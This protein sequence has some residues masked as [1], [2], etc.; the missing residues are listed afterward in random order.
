VTAHA[1]S[2]PLRTFR[3]VL[4]LAVLAPAAAGR[5]ADDATQCLALA[6]YWESKGCSR[7]DMTA[8]GWV[9]LNRIADPDFPDAVCPVVKEGG[10]TPPCQFSWWCDGKSDRPEDGEDWRLARTVAEQL[11]SDPPPDPTGGA[12]FFHSKDITAP[13]SDLQKTAEIDCHIFYK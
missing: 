8:V 6:V 3:L 5:A 9:V 1:A 10:E 13:W 7:K 2:T 12:L 11:Q 4:A